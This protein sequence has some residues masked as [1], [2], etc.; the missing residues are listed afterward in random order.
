[1]VSVCV[2][3]GSVPLAA[4]TVIE[5]T[6]LAVAVPASVAVPL[7]LSLNVRPAGKAPVSVRA[8]VGKLW[9][10]VTV[11]VPVAP[12]INVVLVALVIVGASLTVS[13]KFCVASGLMP[14]AALKVRA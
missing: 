1:M 6:P 8:G 2:A 10:V 7:P 14:L 4:V 13:V 5:K 11:N 3:V 9:P 12:T